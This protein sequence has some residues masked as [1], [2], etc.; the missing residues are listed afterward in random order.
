MTGALLLIRLGTLKCCCLS[1]F[2]QSCNKVDFKVVIG[3]NS[4]VAVRVVNQVES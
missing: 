2:I 3:L 4:K 1:C